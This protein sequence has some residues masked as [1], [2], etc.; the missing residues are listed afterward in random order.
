MARKNEQYR[1]SSASEIL[2]DILAI[3]RKSPKKPLNCK[4]VAIQLGINNKEGLAM[5]E[6]HLATL[7]QKGELQECQKGKFD[8]KIKWEPSLVTLT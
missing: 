4:Q 5:T 2:S 3:F 1:K 8:S 7:E 6:K